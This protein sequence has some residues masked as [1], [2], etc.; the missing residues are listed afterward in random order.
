MSLT[1]HKQLFR[2]Y[3]ICYIIEYMWLHGWDN[4]IK[5][6]FPL[7]SLE[8][9][10]KEKSMIVLSCIDIGIINNVLDCIVEDF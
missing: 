1:T 5:N 8:N 2:Y 4:N 7:F 9:L 6:F 10:N 3:N